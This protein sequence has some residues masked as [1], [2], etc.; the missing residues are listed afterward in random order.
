MVYIIHHVSV[1]QC[2]TQ[3]YYVHGL[4]PSLGILKNIEGFNLAAVIYTTVQVVDH[5]LLYP[6]GTERSFVYVVKTC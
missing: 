4:H 2:I 3:N 5:N 6:A 1:L